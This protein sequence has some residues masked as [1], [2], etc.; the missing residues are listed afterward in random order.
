MPRSQ[1][2]QGKFS[3]SRANPKTLLGLGESAAQDL[4]ESKEMWQI[5]SMSKSPRWPGNIQ[6]FNFACAFIF[7]F[8][9]SS[10]SKIEL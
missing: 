5:L 1:G 9:F 8:S 6:Q 4:P 10:H 7:L 3:R 2:F